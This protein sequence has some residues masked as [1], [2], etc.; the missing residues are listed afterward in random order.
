MQAFA[1]DGRHQ[2]T[3]G[4]APSSPSDERGRGEV[5]TWKPYTMLHTL[6]GIRAETPF[7]LNRYALGNRIL[8]VQPGHEYRKH[9]THE[10]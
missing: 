6:H 2:E 5:R 1:P 8:S 7:L 4:L 10:Q 9:C 3:K